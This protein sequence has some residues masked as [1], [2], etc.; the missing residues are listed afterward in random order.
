MTAATTTDAS[1]ATPTRPD[2]MEITAAAAMD[3]EPLRRPARWRIRAAVLA[4]L[5]LGC[6]LRTSTPT[7][8]DS[9]SPVSLYG[10]A[11]AEPLPAG[12]APAFL[13]VFVQP[14]R[15][16]ETWRSIYHEV[17]RCAGLT[18]HYDSTRW[19]VMQAPMRGPKGRT[20]AFTVGQRIVLVQG[21][22][23]Y[24]RSTDSHS[25]S[26]ASDASIVFPR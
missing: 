14:I 24:L 8:L 3:V 15:A 22:T 10:Q 1:A 16:P 26:L 18:G 13:A 2:L 9:A 21:D 7:F 12:D 6:G 25:R 17:V 23:T 20:N 4:T 19:S 5:V 11:R